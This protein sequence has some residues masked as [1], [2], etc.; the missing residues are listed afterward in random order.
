V[1]VQW[2]GLLSLGFG[3]GVWAEAADRVEKI[4]KLHHS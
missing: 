3:C 2:A 4:S 1:P